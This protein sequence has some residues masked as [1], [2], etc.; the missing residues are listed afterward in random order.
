[1][2]VVS[3]LTTGV[4]HGIVGGGLLAP[5]RSVFTMQLGGGLSYA[6]Q[7][8]ILSFNDF[9]FKHDIVSHSILFHFSA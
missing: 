4:M 6:E 8:S 5:N 7:G 2:V 9:K 1:M 3:H